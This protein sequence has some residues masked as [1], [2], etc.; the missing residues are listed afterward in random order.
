MISLAC[1]L[2]GF[3]LL[4]FRLWPRAAADA[5]PLSLWPKVSIIIPARNE[6]HNL[7]LLLE[8]LQS[9]DYPNFE[10]IVVD[11]N[12]DDETAR[13]AKSFGV[14]VITG[15]AKPEGWFGKPW[16]CHQGSLAATGDYLLFTDADTWH[17]PES[18]KKALAECRQHNAQG[19]TALPYHSNPKLWEQL[20]G[21]FQLLLLALTHPYGLPKKGRVF[22]IGQ[23]LIFDTLFYKQI[24]GHAAIRSQAVDDLSLAELVLAAKGRWF[25]YTG[26]NLYKVRMYTTLPEF[27]K[28]WRRNFRGGMEH[29][30]ALSSLEVVLYFMAMTIG[31]D[32]GKASLLLSVMTLILLAFTQRRIGNFSFL[33]IVFLP[34]SILLFTSIS[35]LAVYDRLR[36]RPLHWK[37]RIYETQ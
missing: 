3:L 33:G 23:Y 17:K 25:V 10:T 37:N 13:I 35:I 6:A 22:A 14:H 21:P 11:D 5:P 4:S 2:C 31:F 9:L 29:N 24:G 28:G 19:M 7:P 30:N 12:S 18:L 27:L 36:A 1:A 20:L 34:F 15:A 32:G 16:A 26:K 8:S